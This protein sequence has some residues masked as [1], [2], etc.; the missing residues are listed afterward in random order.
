MQKTCFFM[1]VLRRVGF[2]H[3]VFRSLNRYSCAQNVLIEHSVFAAYYQHRLNENAHFVNV[4]P[5]VGRLFEPF[6]VLNVVYNNRNVNV[7]P[8]SR[9]PFGVGTIKIYLRSFSKPR[10]ND[11]FILFHKVY[12]F[13][14]GKHFWS[15]HCLNFLVSSMMYSEPLSLSIR[16]TR[17]LC[18]G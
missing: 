12:C 9:M 11:A 16:A 15:I 6:F 14:S 2:C 17:A 1:P 13:V 18:S 10:G 7:A 8:R 3:G 5:Q 4:V